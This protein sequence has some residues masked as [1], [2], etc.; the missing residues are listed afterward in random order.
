MGVAVHPDIVYVTVQ[1]EE[2]ERIIVAKEL[3]QDVFKEIDQFNIVDE[4]IGS[5]LQ[6]LQY[7]APYS[8]MPFEGEA[9][10]VVLADFVTT[11]EGTGIVHMA[12]AFG[13]DDMAMAM[14]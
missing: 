6:G 3:Y 14:K 7:E 5:E 11:G 4:T 9:H 2:G 1:L 8:F 12:A 10:Y 13:A